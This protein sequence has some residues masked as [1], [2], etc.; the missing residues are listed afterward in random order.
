MAYKQKGFPMHSV[1]SA[2]KQKEPPVGVIESMR[3][4]EER[5]RA[6]I[7]KALDEKYPDR[8][9]PGTSIVEDIKRSAYSDEEKDFAY[10]IQEATE[11]PKLGI[12]GKIKPIK[13]TDAE[14]MGGSTDVGDAEG[15]KSR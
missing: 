8:Y 15:T 12:D 1:K 9:I 7:E 4:N 2:L 3:R 13:P 11:K 5:I 14:P 10:K 6:D